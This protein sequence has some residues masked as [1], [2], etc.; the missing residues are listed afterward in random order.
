MQT[1]MTDADPAYTAGSG[2]RALRNVTLTVVRLYS[3]AVAPRP[4][5]IPSSVTL[6]RT[7]V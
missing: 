2:L 7:Y 6:S 1:L 4:E 3:S 5:K